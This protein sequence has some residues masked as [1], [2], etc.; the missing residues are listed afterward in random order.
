MAVIGTLRK[1]STLAIILVGVAIGAFIVSD[2]FTGKG[3]GG[4]NAIPPIGTI[5]GEEITA[6]D[7]NQ[8]VEDNIEIQR[9]NQNKPNLTAAETFDVRQSTWTQYLNEVIMGKEYEK[10]GINVTTDELFDLVQGPR[11]H[12]LIR[13]YFQDPATKQYSPQLVMN[14]LQNL[15]NMKPEVKKQWLNLEKYIKDDRL[16]QKYQALVAKGYYIPAAFADMDYTAKKKNAEIRYV[17]VRYT[18]MKDE[19]VTLTDKDYETYYEKNKQLYDQEPSRD[20][21]YVIFEVLPS[22]EDRQ[23]TKESVYQVYDDFRNTQ[24]YVTFVNSTSDT[25]Y[26]STWHKKG[27]LPV[28]IDS[29]LFSSPVGTFV[30]P[31]EENNAWHMSRLMDIQARPDSMK[32]EH[33]LVSWKGAYKAAETITRTK[34]EAER[35]ADSIM[36]VVNGDKTKLQALAFTLS[37]DGSAKSN[38]GDLGWF[39]DGNM[40]SQFNE[41]CI[42]GT[43]GDIVKVE[44]PFGIHIIKITGKKDPVT[45]IR[46]AT[47]DRLIAPSSKTFQDVYTKAS[48]FA[49]ENNTQTKFETAVTDQGLNKRNATYLREMGNSIAGIEN[50]REIVRWAFTDGF[51][52]G[53]VS[54]VFDVGG[55]YVVAALTNVRGKGIMPLEQVKENIKSFVMNEKKAS[56][57]KDKIKSSGSTDIYQIARDFSSKVDTNLTI[58]FAS[59]NIPGFGSEFQ[60]IGEIFALNEGDVSEPIQG[61]GGVFVVK[62][63]RFYQPPQPPNVTANRDQMIAAFRSRMNQNPM[64]SALQKKTKI[65]DNRLQY[66]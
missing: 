64:F 40:V 57:I 50:P 12:N 42:K 11:P 22:A 48:S 28:T 2:L 36:N 3:R 31:F 61:N 19:D 15:D 52:T 21:D 49:G 39:A 46:V 62:V 41:A 27:Q 55:A 59:R 25:R 20:I 44:S 23:F 24:D 8:R 33:I 66:F 35:R 7:Y 9:T 63:D 53:E 10:L 34:E 30:P 13:Q 4:R 56:I 51:K 58:T 47:I 45:K 29:L 1:H 37:D 43:V 38:N 6:R 18:T 32:A 17:A 5:A 16:S 54:P 14:F 60:V 26:D 65:E